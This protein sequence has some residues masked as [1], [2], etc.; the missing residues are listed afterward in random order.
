A[1][2]ELLSPV[3]RRV[4]AEDLIYAGAAL[5]DA[6]QFESWLETTSAGF[7]YRIHTYSPEIRRPMVWLDHP[8]AGLHALFELLNKHH[9]DHATWFRQTVLQR[10]T[11]ADP[12]TIHAVT[13]LV[14]FHTVVDVGDV[15]VEAGATKLFAVGRYHDRLVLEGGRWLLDARDVHL[16]TRQLGI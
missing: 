3:E 13:Q 7:R 12:S 6:G 11:S 1:M 8:R 4:I 14:I 5:L 2:S 15:H 9:V 16:D 10:A